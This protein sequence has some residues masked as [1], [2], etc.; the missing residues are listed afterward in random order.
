[1]YDGKIYKLSN[2]MLYDKE[3]NCQIVRNGLRLILNAQSNIEMCTLEY[4]RH[5]LISTNLVYVNNAV[6]FQQCCIIS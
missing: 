1:M 3:T 2:V 4:S 6:L 5:Q